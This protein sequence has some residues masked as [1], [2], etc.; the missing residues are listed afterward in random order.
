[1]NNTQMNIDKTQNTSS[2]STADTKKKRRKIRIK[3]T[4]DGMLALLALVLITALVVTALVFALKGIVTAIKNAQGTEDTT[5]PNNGQITLPWNNAYV[6]TPHPNSSIPV[7]DLILVNA[8]NGY[9]LTDSL[10]S[11]NLT[12]LYGY[13]G[14]NTYYVL[15]G[16]DIKVRSSIIQ[17]LKQ[18]IIAMVDENTETLGTSAEG[19]RLYISGAYRDTALQTTLNTNNPTL[20]PETPGYSEHHTGLAVDIKVWSDSTQVNLRDTEYEWLEANCAKYGFIIR[21]DGSKASLTGIADEPYHLRYVGVAH[22]AYMSERNLCL[23]EYLE[24]LRTDHK[25]EQTPLEITANAKEYLVY[26][27]PANTTEGASFTSI[28]VPPASE[29]TYSI[30]GDNMNGFIV[31]VEKTAK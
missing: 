30:S 23:E 20:Y 21:Y 8:Q 10:N 17:S 5:D 24:L 19:D 15:P 22:A 18:L 7:G 1:M 6:P 26:Y 14:H 31:T 3:P 29:G 11:K 4:K 28:P 27:V 13:E 2:F 25:Y 12:N 16:N 9:S